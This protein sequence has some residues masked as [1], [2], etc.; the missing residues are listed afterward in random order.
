[1][2]APDDDQSVAAAASAAMLFRHVTTTF[3]NSNAL[4]VILTLVAD[5]N[6]LVGTTKVSLVATT[7]ELM[8]TTRHTR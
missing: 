6:A 4:V 2:P 1:M 8:D 5:F 7:L 3:P